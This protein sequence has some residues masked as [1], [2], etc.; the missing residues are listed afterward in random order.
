MFENH[1]LIIIRGMKSFWLFALKYEVTSHRM[2]HELTK[3]M[4]KTFFYQRN[5]QI[6]F[7]TRVSG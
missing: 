5:N 3:T 1:V 4:N 2:I 7:L 6:E